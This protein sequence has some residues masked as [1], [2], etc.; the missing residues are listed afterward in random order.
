MVLGVL[1][2]AIWIASLYLADYVANNDM[3]Q[4]LVSQ[5]GYLGILIIAIVSGINVLIP[6]PAAAFVPVFTAAG[7]WLPL[8]ILMLVI[9]T[10]IAD[11]IGYWIGRWSK[12][13]VEEHYP[14]SYRRMK[15]LDE[16]HHSLVLPMVFLYAALI[17]FPNEA[18]LIPLALIG[19]RF[20]TLLIPL[21]LGNVVNQ[22]ALAFGANN[23]FT[24]LFGL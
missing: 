21:V 19:F 12:E 17:P 6:V 13:F 14:Q 8:I 23:I 16:R 22:T 11:L 15:V 1:I 18:M 10:T 24:L 5:F 4:N 9:G 3:A 2:T 7:L 20:K